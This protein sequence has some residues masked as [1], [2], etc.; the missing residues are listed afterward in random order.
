MSAFT[1]YELIRNLHIYNQMTFSYD[2]QTEFMS[3]TINNFNYIS[4]EILS[5]L[6]VHLTLDKAY[7]ISISKYL[8]PVL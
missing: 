2:Y 4:T 6:S 1:G 7:F 8:F 5:I 3:C